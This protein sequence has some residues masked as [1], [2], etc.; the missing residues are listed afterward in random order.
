[1]SGELYY[2]LSEQ[3]QSFVRM[4]DKI[5]FKGSDEIEGTIYCN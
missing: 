1:M 4:V 2:I 5:K 3:V